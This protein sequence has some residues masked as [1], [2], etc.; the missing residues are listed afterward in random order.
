MKKFASVVLF[1]GVLLLLLSGCSNAMDTPTSKVEEFLGKYQRMDDDVVS[2]LDQVLKDDDSMNDDQKEEYRSILE[3]QYQNLS[4]KIE[5]EEINGDN[6]TVDVE[7]EV[8]DYATTIAKAK[9]YYE[10]HKDEIEKENQEEQSDN[11]NVVEDATEGVE[12]AVEESAAYIDYKLKE[13][14]SVSDTT[15]YNIT[16][17]LTKEDGEWKLQDLSDLDLRK[18]HGL[19]EGQIFLISIFLYSFFI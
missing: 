10:E 13:L 16:F 15:T 3:K 7:I 18:I 19:Y 17:Y 14:K 12:E 2:Q 8:L 1:F 5:N 9:E 4:Y 11:D 6:A